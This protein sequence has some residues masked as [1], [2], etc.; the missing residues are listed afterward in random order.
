MRRHLPETIDE[1]GKMLSRVYK[2]QGSASFGKYQYS[3][4]KIL[5]LGRDWKLVKKMLE[6]AKDIPNPKD[7]LID[8]ISTI[9]LD[10]SINSNIRVIAADT[11]RVLI[12]RSMSFTV[13]KGTSI[14]QAM[15][16]ILDSSQTKTFRDA[17]CGV[18]QVIDTETNDCLRAYS[19]RN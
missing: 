8:E 6:Y 19:M 4:A 2:T 11:L 13:S 15:K 5:H 9:M 1:W 12:P 14:T 18:L 16:D 17:V 7:V 3:I 10:S